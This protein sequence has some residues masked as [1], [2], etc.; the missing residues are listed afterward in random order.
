MKCILLDT[1]GCAYSTFVYDL[2]QCIIQLEYNLPRRL[3]FVV[4]VSSA[5]EY[6]GSRY[7]EQFTMTPSDS[8]GASLVEPSKMKVGYFSNEFPHDDLR[9]LVRCLQV[10]SKDLRHTTLAR[11]ITEATLAIREEVRLLPASLRTLVQPFE[12]VFNFADQAALRNGRLGGAIDG[13]LLC[14]VQIATL[15]G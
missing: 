12:T 1:A 14:A 11:F 5:M 4:F 8:T 2:F 3:L 7:Q 9:D 10:H 15:I 6:I 13:V